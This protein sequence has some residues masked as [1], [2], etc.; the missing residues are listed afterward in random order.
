MEASKKI[1]TDVSELSKDTVKRRIMVFFKGCDYAKCLSPHC[2]HFISDHQLADL[3]ADP[4]NSVNT[5][6]ELIQRNELKITCDV[7]KHFPLFLSED[8]KSLRPIL[9]FSFLKALNLKSEDRFKLFEEIKAVS[10]SELLSQSID[11]KHRLLEVFENGIAEE[12]SVVMEISAKKVKDADL[13]ESIVLFF[14]TFSFIFDIE[15]FHNLSSIK[16]FLEHLKLPDI[17]RVDFRQH[18]Q[19]PHARSILNRQTIERINE[20]L[21]NLLA[22]Q[23]AELDSPNKFNL[24]EALN[25]SAIASSISFVSNLNSF[26]LSNQQLSS[27]DFV[28]ETLSNDFDI[29]NSTFFFMR[30]SLQNRPMTN[31]ARLMT[32]WQVFE[33]FTYLSYPVLLPVEIKVDVLHLESRI[34]QS[35]ELQNAFMNIENPMMLFLSNEAYLELKLRRD[36]LLEDALNQLAGKGK[37]ATLRKGLKIKFQ[38]EPGV[39]EG[40]LTKEFFQLLTQQLFDP[41]FGMF[42]EKNERYL[43]FDSKSFECVFNFELVGTLLGL[44]LYNETI[45]PLKFPLVVYKKLKLANHDAFSVVDEVGLEDLKEIEPEVYNTLVN[46]LNTDWSYIETGMTF[47][48]TYDFY[49]TAVNYELIP[50][51]L[52]IAVTE[53]NKKEF[54]DRYLNW[55]FNESVQNQ[56]EPFCR[57]FYN[58]L[59]KKTLALFTA[60]DLFLAICGSEELNFQALR[61]TTKYEDY[62][63]HS[64]TIAHFWQILQTDF[65]NDQKKA[66][67]KFLTGSDR[68]PIKGLSDIK[69]T[70]TR[71][72]PDSEHLPA[73]HTCF[74][75][76][77][78]PDY[79]NYHKL[80][81]KLLKA[82]ENCE[83]FG[84]F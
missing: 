12:L 29:K 66:F 38:G 46:I 82:V 74:N 27:K 65:N 73:S 1:K 40:G 37:G 42:L 61:N 41:S 60:S 3:R 59:S 7:E 48:V 81:A 22:L 2:P 67:L 19:T 33:K 84:L 32:A 64:E 5:V 63:E 23:I 79:K 44:A 31:I 54:V 49:G 47:S 11:V 18:L 56:F 24:A 34:L 58:V 14:L 43:W 21:Q 45:L 39:D 78:L 51:G 53:L 9:D 70:I 4:E 76:L 50:G 71:Y 13:F 28:N 35:L 15:N 52:E 10:E 16:K 25:L 30:E 6:I 17:Y 75:H 72:G 57:G 80:R 83:G 55:Y 62:Y 20:N 69:M 36:N 26:L 77:L 68:A 8:L